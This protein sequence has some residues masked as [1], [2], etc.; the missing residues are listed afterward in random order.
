MKI[1]IFGGSFNPVH[2][3]HIF[4]AK[5][6]MEKK[7]LDKIIFIPVGLP[8]HRENNLL[9]S[10]HRLNILSLALENEKSFEISDI[11]LKEEKVSYTIDTLRKIKE[12]YPNDEIYE[13]IGEDSAA[14]F[15]K[16]K[17]YK[18]V[19]KLSKVLVFMRKNSIVKENFENMEFLDTPYIDISATMVRE[20]IRKGIDISNLIDE[21]VYEY[22]KNNKLYLED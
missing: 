14:Y 5:Y 12:I 22:I 19:L 21:K 2:N 20:N 8:S 18:E 9:S 11:E 15:E 6:I 4:I 7:S 10:K 3:G 13:I 17:D 1:G 16:W